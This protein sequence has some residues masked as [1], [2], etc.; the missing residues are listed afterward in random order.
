MKIK[1][2]KRKFVKPVKSYIFKLHSCPFNKY[3][4]SVVANANLSY[5]GPFL[6][7]QRGSSRV[8]VNSKVSLKISTKTP[9]YQVRKIPSFYCSVDIL[10]EIANWGCIIEDPQFKSLSHAVNILCS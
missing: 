9:V 7:L 5:A 10:H 8:M 3:L 4:V 2:W 6:R 1:E